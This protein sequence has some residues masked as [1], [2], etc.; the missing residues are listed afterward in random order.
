VRDNAVSLA[1]GSSRVLL[2]GGDGGGNRDGA[3]GIHLCVCVLVADATGE[4]TAMAR[5]SL[6]DFQ[7]PS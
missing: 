6:Y 7:T 1:A 4:S 5:R 3:E 2:A